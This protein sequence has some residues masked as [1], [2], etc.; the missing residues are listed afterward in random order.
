M[1]SIDV[2]RLPIGYIVPGQSWSSTGHTMRSH[3]LVRAVS[4]Y[5]MPC[6]AQQ[7]VHLSKLFIGHSQQNIKASRLL[8]VA[9]RS[10][11]QPH[12]GAHGFLHKTI[13]NQT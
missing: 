13:Q 5:T 10:L 11:I 3:C 2:E 1:L 12:F 4:V 7:L 6:L 8:P 9:P